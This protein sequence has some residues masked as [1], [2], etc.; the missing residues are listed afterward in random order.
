MSFTLEDSRL[1]KHVEG[2]AVAP[3]SLKPK[4]DDS[5]D[6]ME[7]IFAREEKICE[8]EDNARKAVGKIGKMCT[9]TVQKE[10]LLVKASKE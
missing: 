6:R 7:K 8:F 10:F 2:T 4:E 3:P 9:D 5:E 1:W